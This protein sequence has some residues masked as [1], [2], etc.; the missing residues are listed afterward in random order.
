[1]F[2]NYFREVL[3]VNQEVSIVVNN[4]GKIYNLYEKASDRL[5]EIIPFSRKTYHKEYSALEGVSFEVKAGET[6]GIIGSNGAGKSTLLKLITGVAKPTGGSIQVLG[7]VSALLELGAGF[8][9]D[10]TGIQNIYLNGTMMGYK[11]CEME[12]KV[13]RLWLSLILVILYISL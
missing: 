1:M 4:V 11:R 3:I 12:P 2:F 6:F 10:Y 5:R 13:N 9:M 8:N 7:K